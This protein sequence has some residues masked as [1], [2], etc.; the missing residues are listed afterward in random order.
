MPCMGPDLNYARK[1]GH[2][3]GEKL[4]ADLIK[5]HSLWDI[6]ADECKQQDFVRLPNAEKRW[7]KAK[8]GFIK[9]VEKLFVEDAANGF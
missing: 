3:V 7:N 6:T 2:I 5:K 8:V 1:H 9:A 4:F